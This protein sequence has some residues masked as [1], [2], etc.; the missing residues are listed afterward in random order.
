MSSRG[1]VLATDVMSGSRTPEARYR[2]LSPLRDS[3]SLPSWEHVHGP[4]LPLPQRAPQPGTNPSPCIPGSGCGPPP[5]KFPKLCNDICRQL[6]GSVHG[7]LPSLPRGPK[8]ALTIASTFPGACVAHCHDQESHTCQHLFLISLRGCV[9]HCL[10]SHK[11]HDKLRAC[12]CH[13]ALGGV[14]QATA[15]SLTD[16]ITSQHTAPGAIV[17]PHCSHHVLW[18]HVQDANM[19]ENSGIGKSHCISTSNIKHKLREEETD[20]H[21]KYSETKGEELKSLLPIV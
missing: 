4:W 1:W 12:G 17:S 11:A 16:S 10:R 2:S 20:I 3:L 13:W 7:P 6:P 14:A 5:L 21:I 19:T 15:I 18:R 8:K 9:T